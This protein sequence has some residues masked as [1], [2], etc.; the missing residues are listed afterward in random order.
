MDS[1]T[2]TINEFSDASGYGDRVGIMNY[3]WGLKSGVLWPNYKSLNTFN[4]TLNNRNKVR[5]SCLL[6]F[7]EVVMKVNSLK[8]LRLRINASSF[9]NGD[10]PKYDFSKLVGKSPSLELIELT[11]CHYEDVCIWLETLKWEKQ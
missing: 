8:I 3:V 10:H 2:L 1:F 9:K 6:E 4:L 5:L 7:F 11:L